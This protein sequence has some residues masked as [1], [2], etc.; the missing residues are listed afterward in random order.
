MILASFIKQM[1]G[2][3]DQTELLE[4][5]NWDEEL[6]ESFVNELQAMLMAAPPNLEKALFWLKNTPWE[7]FDN[8]LIP[9][10]VFATIEI[11]IT[12]TR[13]QILVEEEARR[14]PGSLMSA[15]SW[16]PDDEWN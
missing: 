8:E 1:Q 16:E 7:C 4:C 13:D 6:T 15:N 9:E 14:R 2:L 3:R 11:L 12:R 5:L 10:N